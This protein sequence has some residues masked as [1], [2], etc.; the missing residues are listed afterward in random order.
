MDSEQKIA[1]AASLHG[2]GGSACFAAG[3][4][5]Y[6]Q[7]RRG[8]AELLKNIAVP[9]AVATKKRR[10]ASVS[11]AAGSYSAGLSRTHTIARHMMIA[12]HHTLREAIQSPVPP[13]SLSH[14][15]VIDVVLWFIQHSL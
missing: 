7:S 9:L 14:R 4:A 8:P 13:S 6:R 5:R 2:T 15:C 10:A 1:S 11:I 12:I 3:R